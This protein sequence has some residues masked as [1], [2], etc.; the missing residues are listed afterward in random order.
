MEK[1]TTVGYFFSEHISGAYVTVGKPI[2]ISKGGKSAIVG[3]I[4][5]LFKG[6]TIKIACGQSGKTGKR[7]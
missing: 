6:D 7:K 5:K 2:H 3:A 1:I 4:I